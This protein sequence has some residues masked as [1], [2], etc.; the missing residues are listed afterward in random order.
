MLLEKLTR[1]YLPAIENELQQIVAQA[2]S[3]RLAELHSIIAY[4]LGWEGQEAGPQ[5][6]GKRIRPLLVLLTAAAAG[7]N[8]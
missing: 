1:L 2:N 3:P 8:H 5:A 6:R 4:H 7:L